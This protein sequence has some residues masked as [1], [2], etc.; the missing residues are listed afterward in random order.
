MVNSLAIE[1]IA[2]AKNPPGEFGGVQYGDVMAQYWVFRLKS[3]QYPRGNLLL[4]PAHEEA[5][6]SV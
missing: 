5:K 2:V 1:Q 6:A 4:L 3:A